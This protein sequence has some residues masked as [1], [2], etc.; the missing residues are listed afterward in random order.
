MR[1]I[2]VVS[3]RE[4]EAL[5]TRVIVADKT[6][7]KDSLHGVN[8]PIGVSTHQL[9]DALPDQLRESL[10]TIEQAKYPEQNS[11]PP[12]SGVSL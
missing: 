3:Q 4:Y 6:I 2:P 7:V 10:P 8:K 1:E 5:S 11:F 9:G 12:P